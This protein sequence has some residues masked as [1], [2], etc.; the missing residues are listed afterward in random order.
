MKNYYKITDGKL[1]ITNSSV[2][3]ESPWTEYELGSE[4][5]DLQD[6]LDLQK[7]EAEDI[8]KIGEAFAYLKDTDFYYARKLETGEEVPT[9][10]VTKRD[11]ARQF[12]RSKGY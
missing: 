4:P 9:E 10:V 2:E 3:L 8:N 12:L 1:E 6:A 7:Q 5:Q 11:E